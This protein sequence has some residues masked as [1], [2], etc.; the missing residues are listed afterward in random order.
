MVIYIKLICISNSSEERN[1]RKVVIAE[2]EEEA[3]CEAVIK[4][5]VCQITLFQGTEKLG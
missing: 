5:S 1:G 2:A 4:V 3:T